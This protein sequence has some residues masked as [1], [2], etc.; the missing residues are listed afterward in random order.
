MWNQLLRKVEFPKKDHH[1]S[2]ALPQ[3]PTGDHFW[4]VEGYQEGALHGH[5]AMDTRA[6]SATV[7]RR[8]SA[9]SG[10]LRR[11]GGNTTCGAPT[12]VTHGAM[13]NSGGPRRSMINS[14][15]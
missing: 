3:L 9:T 2:T 7:P 13:V 12:E 14:G 10:G 11:E 8:I 15:E 4:L 5:L 1:S 6:A